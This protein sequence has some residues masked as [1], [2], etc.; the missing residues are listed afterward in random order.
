MSSA[1]G[2]DSLGRDLTSQDGFAT[3]NFRTSKNE[4]FI[5]SKSSFKEMVSHQVYWSSPFD[6]IGLYDGRKKD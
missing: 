4:G 3:V 5:G 6:K 1:I 2:F